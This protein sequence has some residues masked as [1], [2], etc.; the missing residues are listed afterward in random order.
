MFVLG[1]SFLIDLFQNKCCIPEVWKLQQFV[2]DQIGEKQL[3][4]VGMY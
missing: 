1:M 4:L 2:I 3:E